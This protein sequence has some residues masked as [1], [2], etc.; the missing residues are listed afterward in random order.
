[1]PDPEALKK[2]VAFICGPDEASDEIIDIEC[3]TYCEKLAIL[4][5]RVASGEH[6][7]DILPAYEEHMCSSPDCREEFE[8]LVAVVRAERESKLPE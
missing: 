5:D 3:N 1:M 8:A 7:R 2:L 6:L 4:A